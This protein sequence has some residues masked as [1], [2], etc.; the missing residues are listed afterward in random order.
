MAH[1]YF[2]IP[3]HPKLFISPLNY[4]FIFSTQKLIYYVQNKSIT[5]V[6]KFHFWMYA[7]CY[8]MCEA[9]FYDISQ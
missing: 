3:P 9:S 6:G 8:I 5:D 2:S 4:Y 7:T 1:F